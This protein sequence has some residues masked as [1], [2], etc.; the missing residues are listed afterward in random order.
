MKNLLVYLSG[1]FVLALVIRISFV[2]Q[3]NKPLTK[4]QREIR[5]LEIENENL[6]YQFNQCKI[7]YR[8]F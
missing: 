6:R 8:G 7:M 4:E 3:Q 2:T 1:V 5:R